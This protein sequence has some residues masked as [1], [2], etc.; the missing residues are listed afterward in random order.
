[1]KVEVDFMSF[2]VAAVV[3]WAVLWLSPNPQIT[4]LTDTTFVKQTAIYT[5]VCDVKT[6]TCVKFD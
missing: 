5:R 3:I 2:G 6:A 1:M 4:R